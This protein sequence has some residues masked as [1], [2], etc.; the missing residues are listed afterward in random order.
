MTLSTDDLRAGDSPARFFSH[1]A[2][3]GNEA[4]GGLTVAGFNIEN[5]TTIALLT[6]SLVTAALIAVPAL[7]PAMGV[8]AQA[9]AELIG[10]C[11]DNIYPH[12]GFT[13]QLTEAIQ[14]IPYIGQMIDTSGGKNLLAPATFMLG[15]LVLGNQVEQFEKSH[16]G[17]GGIGGFLRVTGMVLGSIIALPALLPGIAHSLLFIGRITGTES[18]LRPLVTDIGTNA[19]A[20]L[21]PDPNGEAA[22]A[23]RS[24]AVKTAFSTVTGVQGA[25]SVLAGHAACFTPAML[26]LAGALMPTG[27]SNA[28]KLLAGR[29]AAAGAQQR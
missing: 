13:A 24:G 15:G 28:E 1:A 17:D 29:D 25:G 23:I 7:L 27:L 8:G 10:E 6:T 14:N 19:C 3:V 4:G 11:C 16:G 22:A 5:F 2:H 12:T 18:R 21:G 9:E 20:V 26:A